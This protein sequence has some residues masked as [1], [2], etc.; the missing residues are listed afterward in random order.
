MK[1]II[2]AGGSGSRLYPLTR[3]VSKQ[4]LPC[5]DKPVI[6]YP[7]SLLM[8][9]GIRDILIISTPHDLPLIRTLLGDGGHLGLSL[10]YA[11]QPRPNGIAEA[12]LIGEEFLA[13]SPACLILGDNFFYGHQLVPL[14]EDAAALDSGALVFAYQVQDPEPLRRGRVRPRSPRASIEEKPR[15]PRSNWAVTGLY[16]YDDRVVDIARRIRPS[17]RGELE[18]T[19]VNQT[20]LREGALTVATL[21]R[22]VAWLDLGTPP[23]LLSASQFVQTLEQRTG[24]KI[25][26][27]E[28][29][30]LHRGFIGRDQF[31]DLVRQAGSSDY[32]KYLD[33]V[34]QE[35]VGTLVR[36]VVNRD[37]A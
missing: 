14:L 9:A 12:F 23:S 25:A 16:F 27:V 20:Y 37:A 3:V 7:L 29:I 28:E 18:I 10:H 5:Y 31:A 22:G 35:H 30:A 13:G 36:P 11:A 2:L 32:G 1:G 21:G 34:L 17:A 4:L 24:L 33:R 15:H 19:E 6:Y 8:L 26:C